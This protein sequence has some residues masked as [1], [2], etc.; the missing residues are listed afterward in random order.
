MPDETNKL[1]CLSFLTDQERDVFLAVARSVALEPHCLLWACVD[2]M[3]VRA[4][5]LKLL[6]E[7]HE[8]A[9]KRF[10]GYI[11]SDWAAKNDLSYYRLIGQTEIGDQ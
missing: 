1:D 5:D 6:Q 9:E 4:C 3:M 8:A 2:A 7:Y 10:K 11:L